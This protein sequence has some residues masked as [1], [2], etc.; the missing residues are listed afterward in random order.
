M[1]K[2]LFGT[3]GIPVGTKP[4]NTLEGIKQVKKLGLG[5]MEL[6]FVRSINISDKKAPEVR[7]LA[8]QE[9][10]LLSAHAPYFINLNAVDPEKRKASI[11]RILNSARILNLCGGWSVCFH[12]GFYMGMPHD[13]VYQS[14][15]ESLEAITEALK[16]EGI[17]LWVRPEIGGKPTSWGSLE[18]IIKISQELEGVQP[19]IDWAHLHARSL[20]KNNSYSEFAAVLETIEKG[21]G[22][23]ALK[24]MHCHAEGIEFG[25]KG[26]R[27]HSNLGSSLN[28]QDLMKA[29]KDFSVKGVLISE[30]PNIEGDALL[31]KKVYD[32][33]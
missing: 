33:L 23:E 29:L 30:S 31:M 21:L 32:S 19:C 20:G 12:A 28:Y 18:E 8:K 14:V 22:K 5:C 2:L 24:N 10:V 16:T 17:K 1:E 9:N 25:P 13:K 4:R 7:K 11:G 3:A 15:R 27:S 6:E 26:E